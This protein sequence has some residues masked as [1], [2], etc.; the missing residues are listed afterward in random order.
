MGCGPAARAIVCVPWVSAKTTQRDKSREYCADSRQIWV[1]WLLTKADEDLAPP[2][3]SDARP[4]K[5][6]RIAVDGRRVSEFSLK[7]LYTR[8]HKP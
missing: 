8:G 5:S 2:G 6:D 3:K 7:S 1:K 4:I